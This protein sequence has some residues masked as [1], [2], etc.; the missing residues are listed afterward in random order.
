MRRQF[1][2]LLI[3][4]ARA[5]SRHLDQNLAELSLSHADGLAV[6]MLG[7]LDDGVRQGVLAE[8]LGIE[9]PSVVPLVDRME[10]SGLVERRTDPSDRRGRTLHLTDAGRALA[11]R[12]EEHADAVRARLFADIPRDAMQATVSVLDHVHEAL[13][14]PSARS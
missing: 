13:N 7:R 10:R 1:G 12:A 5:Y 4:L 2:S 9:G 14:A 3:R 6:M 8:R 11:I